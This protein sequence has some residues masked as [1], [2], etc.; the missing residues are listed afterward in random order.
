MTCIIVGGGV[1]GFQAATTC[2]ALWPERAVTLID[3]EKETGYYRTL[4]P[5]FMAGALGE[6]KL[7]FWRGG[8]D[9]L[10]TVR[11]GLR[12]TS[13]LATRGC[14]FQCTYC[15]PTLERLFG[16]GLRQRSPAGVVNELQELQ[17]RY[18]LSAFLFADDTFIA[19]RGW[20]QS[21]C[22]ELQARKLNLI[23]GCN[24]RADL[25]RKEL[26]AEMRDAGLAQVRVGIEAYSDRVRNEVFRKKV[27][28]EQVEE[29]TRAARSLKLAS[30]GYF[31][32]GAP[33]ETREEVRATVRWARRL[34]I[35]DANFNLTTP[36]PRRH[37]LCDENLSAQALADAVLA[38]A[39]ELDR[40]RPNDDT[41]V[42][43]ARVVPRAS[44]DGARRLVV[45][46]PI[47]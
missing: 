21:F 45:R 18:G 47:E 26:L 28:R 4:L 39:V 23:W 5:Q 38:H 17:E 12:G 34:P 24:V 3:A 13:V 11:P 32:L 30:Q 36:L 8:D 31:M 14:P 35:D 2:Q 37:M 6:E 40:G 9:P 25:A 43:V 27:S 19:D 22:R 1:A 7:F 29:V 42:L 41:S 46:F 16:R 20:V 10:L 33:G 44:E 15:Q